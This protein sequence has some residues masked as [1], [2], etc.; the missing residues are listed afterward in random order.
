MGKFPNAIIIKVVQKTFRFQSYEVIEV[1][2]MSRPAKEEKMAT[3]DLTMPMVG[4]QTIQCQ[5]PEL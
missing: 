3:S 5:I 2:L 4:Y 1:T